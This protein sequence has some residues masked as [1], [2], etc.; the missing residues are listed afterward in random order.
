MQECILDNLWYQYNN[1]RDDKGYFLSIL[2]SLAEYF[3][4]I[5]GKIPSP[6]NIEIPEVKPLYIL[7]DGKTPGIYTTFEKIIEEKTAAKYTGGVT[8][9]K[10]TNI[11]EALSLARKILGINY[12]IE[13]EA[14]EYIQK[15]KMAQ[16]KMN[17]VEIPITKVKE[18]GQSS[19]S[20]TY[21]ECLVKGADPI[22]AQYIA[23]KVEEKLQQIYPQWKKEIKQEILNEVK[24]EVKEEFDKIKKEYDD[25]DHLLKYEEEN[26]TDE[27]MEDSQHPE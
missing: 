11:E 7:Y 17:P 1:K 25:F 12:H 8:W 6:E 13:P 23:I 19:K 24:E 27:T 20:K 18:E 10:Y 16:N 3:N 22:D 9:K 21:K 15:H 4:M 5:N 14:K 2:N 26:K